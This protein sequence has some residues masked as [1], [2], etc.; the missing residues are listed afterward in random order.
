MSARGSR[1]SPQTSVRVRPP[2]RGSRDADALLPV[3][4][5]TLTEPVAPAV[6][7]IVVGL[8]VQTVFVGRLPQANVN[9]PDWPE[10]GVMVRT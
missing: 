3:P 8:K 1:I 5:A 7:V 4:R 10:A 6:I 9:V 2:A